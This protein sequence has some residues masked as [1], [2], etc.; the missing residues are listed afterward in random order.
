MRIVF[1]IGLVIGILG[2]IV[3]IAVSSSK[4]MG[5][6]IIG[7]IIYSIIAIFCGYK[8]KKIPRKVKQKTPSVKR[9][10]SVCGSEQEPL[11]V[12]RDGTLCANCFDKL[13][14][15][16]LPEKELLKLRKISVAEAKEKIKNNNANGTNF[17]PNVSYSSFSADTKSNTFRIRYALDPFNKKFKE[18]F[19]K[20]EDVMSY[21]VIED[22][23]V[24]SSG[25][26]GR[27]A[28]GAVA[29]GGVGA[30]VGAVTGKKKEKKTVNKLDILLR[31][32]STV[33]PTVRIP[34]IIVKTKTSS[35]A[36]KKALND[37]ENIISIFEAQKR[38]NN[39]KKEEENISADRTQELRNYKQLLDDNIITQEEFEAKKK[40]ILG[41]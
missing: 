28:V 11:K 21:E 12:I 37:C 17:I 22:G 25:G 19:H 30:V 33:F 29:F 1:L 41:I 40:E 20:F 23:E 38:H 5:D 13:Y 2:D 14:T 9:K 18:E 27:A 15:G 8:L 31:L 39:V 10:C 3:M 36:Y 4:N 35:T 6:S 7:I 16:T 24:T 34:L 26:L 32:D